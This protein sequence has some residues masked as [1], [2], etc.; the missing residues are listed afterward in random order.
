MFSGIIERGQCHEMGELSKSVTRKWYHKSSVI[1]EKV[2]SQIGCFKETKHVKFSEKRT[3]LT[4]VCVSGGKKCSF[5]GKFDMLCFLETPVL[6][7]ALLSYYQRNTIGNGQSISFCYKFVSYKHTMDLV[8]TLLLLTTI[9][10]ITQNDFA[11]KNHLFSTIRISS[12]F[13][14][15]F[16]AFFCEQSPSKHLP[17]QSQQ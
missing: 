11:T 14:Q 3:F 16:S 10:E 5:F 8:T 2:E 17:V 9:R 1:R 15:I 13:V 12:S 6:R 7:F 4:Y